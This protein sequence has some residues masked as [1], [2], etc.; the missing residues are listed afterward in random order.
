MIGASP[1]ASAPEPDCETLHRQYRESLECFAPFVNANG[2]LKPNAFAACKSMVD[3]SPR[4]GP[5]K[6][7]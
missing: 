2:T 7:N 3:P 6:A 5:A 1:G 4:C